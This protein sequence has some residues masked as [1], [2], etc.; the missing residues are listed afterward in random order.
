M[1][2]PRLFLVRNILGI[3]PDQMTGSLSSAFD[4]VEV[5]SVT[6]IPDEA[7][8]FLITPVSG[9]TAALIPALVHLHEPLGIVQCR[10]GEWTM[11]WGNRAM[12]ALSEPVRAAFLHACRESASAISRAGG[13]DASPPGEGLRATFQVGTDHFELRT[14]VASRDARGAVDMLAGLIWETTE[15]HRLRSR[16]DAVDAAGS[17]LLRIDTAMIKR[18]NAAERLRLLQDRIV[19]TVREL[20][21]FE[22]FEVRLIDQTT[23]QLELVFAHGLA[24]LRIG[25]ALFA[26]ETGNGICGVVAVT[27]RTY[28]S[29]DV[30]NDPLYHEGL[31]H[32]R[33]S[34]TVPLHLHDHVIGVFNVESA[35][36]DAFDAEDER[37]AE[38]LGRYIAMAMHILDLLVVE[39][40]TTN[41]QMARNVVG[42]IKRPLREIAERVESARKGAI[43]LEVQDELDRI[44]QLTDEVRR[45]VEACAAG[46]STLLGADL[47]DEPAGGHPA[48]MHKRVL[49]CDNEAA[50]LES[51]RALLTR[52]GCMVTAMLDAAATIALLEQHAG[53][54]PPFDLVISDIRMPQRN[55]YEVFRAARAACPGTPVILMTGFGYDPHHSIVRAHQEGLHAF[56][57]KPIRAA[58]FLDAVSKALSGGPREA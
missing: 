31:E 17:E 57:F 28:R 34:L 12:Q 7:G 1:S 26:R 35:E 33:S 43:R 54:P 21:H 40:F 58:A 44:I 56:L 36:P 39:R 41:E 53:G 27:G 4:L 45:R 55:G 8:S 47:E 9:G 16:L 48:L 24:P 15:R 51:I 37:L 19:A 18:L 13:D 49:I 30:T 38:V 3:S 5:E 46:P 14:A 2:R 25:E 22:H 42:E 20:L 11:R 29:G 50:V 23:R 32:A 10:D 6:A 52:K